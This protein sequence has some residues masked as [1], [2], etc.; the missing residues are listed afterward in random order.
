MLVLTREIGAR[1]IIGDDII[2]TVVGLS[3]CQARLGID[4]PRHITVHREEI[5]EKMLAERAALRGES[6]E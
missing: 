1:I 2:V 6:H 4:A 5:Y 3:G